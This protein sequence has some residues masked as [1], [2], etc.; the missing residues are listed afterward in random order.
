[1]GEAGTEAT[2]I[3]GLMQ[4][5]I[6]D[7]HHDAGEL[8]SPIFID[9]EDLEDLAMLQKHVEG[10]G[11]LVILLTPGILTR[12]WCLLEIVTAVRSGVR[13]VPVEVQKPGIKYQYPDDE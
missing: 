4:K 3:R 5:F 12:P 10:S 2:L 6:N 1:M 9:S 13:F 8:L 11:N 7:E